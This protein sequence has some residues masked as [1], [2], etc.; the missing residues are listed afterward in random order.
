MTSPQ[1]SDLAPTLRATLTLDVN[2]TPD[3]VPPDVLL[4]NLKR[5]C[6]SAICEG[7]L[8]GN[9]DAEVDAYSVQAYVRPNLCEARLAE[10]FLQ[11]ITDGDLPLVEIPVRLARYGLMQPAAF[12]SELAE[13]MGTLE[14]AVVTTA[15]SST[16]PAADKLAAGMA[17]RTQAQAL[18]EAA[19][20]LDGLVCFSVTH[21][22][23]YGASTY[24][25]WSN[26]VPDEQ[27]AAAITDAEFEPDRGESLSI[28]PEFT[29]AELCGVSEASR[30]TTVPSQPQ[31]PQ[32]GARPVQEA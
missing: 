23:E 13:S 16:S 26:E 9:T 19:M 17:L 12:T 25:L 2:C 4:S 21:A 30:V 6:E 3:G 7:A 24:L 15:C 14:S 32:T 22:H 18:L 20:A 28:E 29:L 27:A 8:T 1:V 31:S 11:E 10:H 5:V